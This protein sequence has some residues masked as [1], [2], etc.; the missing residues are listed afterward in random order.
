MSD[1]K[2]LSHL[3]IRGAL[4]QNASAKREDGLLTSF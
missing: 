4:P 1:F 3:L 2:S